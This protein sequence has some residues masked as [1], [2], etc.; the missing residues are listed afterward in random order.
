M[1][2][3]VHLE[4]PPRLQAIADWIPSGARMVDIG[5]DHGYLPVWLLQEGK[6]QSAVA[7]DIGEQPLQ[8]A[9]D[10]AQRYGVAMSFRQCDG[11]AAISP[12]EV[13][14]V[15]IAGMGGETIIHILQA[16]PWTKE[17]VTLLLQPMSKPELL[18]RWLAENGYR[19]TRERLVLDRG[20]IYPI[21]QC[22]GG[23][24][25][26]PGGG[27]ACYGYAGEQDPL[28]GQY[29]HQWIEKTK[30]ALS[31]L[32]KSTSA[33]IQTRRLDMERLLEELEERSGGRP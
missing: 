31:G 22:I 11:L 18:R 6:I 21:L 10:S 3:T 5:T 17:E 20:L 12:F 27:L 25:E 19:I 29:L 24:M 28:F 14:T 33:E 4:L 2:A 15:S 23:T 8:R 16:A 32:E 1:S 13:D 30:R 26:V 7:T 9:R